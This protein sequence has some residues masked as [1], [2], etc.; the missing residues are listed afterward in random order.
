MRRWFFHGSRRAENQIPPLSY[1]SAFPLRRHGGKLWI[2]SSPADASSFMPS[3]LGYDTVSEG[4][5]WEEMR[6]LHRSARRFSFAAFKEVVF[7]D[8]FRSGELL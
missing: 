7:G 6:L 2:A 1:E 5:G 4:E 8:Q 3:R